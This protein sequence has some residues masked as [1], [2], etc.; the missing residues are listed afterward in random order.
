MFFTIQTKDLPEQENTTS[1][2]M[3]EFGL[4][5]I[6]LNLARRFGFSEEKK[7][8]SDERDG[9]PTLGSSAGARPRFYLYS[10]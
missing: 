4:E 10:V 6:G 2:I 9:Q 8:S 7:E 3:F 5:R 1:F